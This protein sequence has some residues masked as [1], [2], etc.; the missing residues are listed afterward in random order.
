MKT[1]KI[2]N[3]NKLVELYGEIAPNWVVKFRGSSGNEYKFGLQS[4]NTKVWDEFLFLINK[5]VKVVYNPES[6]EPNYYVDV[7]I[8]DV[9]SYKDEITNTIKLEEFKNPQ[10][11]VEHMIDGM[12]QIVENRG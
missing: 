4:D 8:N 1:L 2:E 12:T 10:K 3:P 7:T 6:F 5:E 9:T 11:V